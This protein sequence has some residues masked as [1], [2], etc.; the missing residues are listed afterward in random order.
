M[1]IPQEQKTVSIIKAIATDIAQHVTMNVYSRTGASRFFTICTPICLIK[2]LLII[3]LL[4]TGCQ[5]QTSDREI[6]IQAAIFSVVAGA[7]CFIFWCCFV[8]MCIPRHYCRSSSSAPYTVHRSHNESDV[9]PTTHAIR[10]DQQHLVQGH[11]ARSTT[12]YPQLAQVGYSTSKPESV[13]LPE[14]TLHHSDAP[15]DYEEA[16]RM[17]PID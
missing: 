9:Y 13:S 10:Y 16:I 5:A 15:P 7:M 11:I 3:A 14:A 2:L 17:A 1:Y 4:P 12:L 8:L 6:S